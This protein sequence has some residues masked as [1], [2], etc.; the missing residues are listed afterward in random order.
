MKIFSGSKDTSTYYN[1]GA[2]KSFLNRKKGNN[3][4]YTADN[5]FKG[6]STTKSNGSQDSVKQTSKKS[7]A[8]VVKKS[9]KKID[10]ERV[11]NSIINNELKKKS[12]G[13][14][15]SNYIAFMGV[16]NLADKSDVDGT[17]TSS[18]CKS[19]KCKCSCN[20]PITVVS[21]KSSIL[22]CSEKFKQKLRQR[23]AKEKF[24]MTKVRPRRDKKSDIEVSTK[25]TKS[26]IIKKKPAKSFSTTSKSSLKSAQTQASVEIPSDQPSTSQKG[27]PKTGKSHVEFHKSASKLKQHKSMFDLEN[28]AV[29]ERASVTSS[30]HSNRNSKDQLGHA[31]GSTI[32]GHNDL[33][34][35]LVSPSYFTEQCSGEFMRGKLS[36]HVDGQSTE[37]VQK[38]E[39]KPF[40][41]HNGEP[42]RE[43]VVSVV[44]YDEPNQDC[45]LKA[46]TELISEMEVVNDIPPPNKTDA[47]ENKSSSEKV[48]PQTIPVI[49]D[50]SDSGANQPKLVTWKDLHGE[51]LQSTNLEETALVDQYTKSR[52]ESEK[53]RK[54][55]DDDISFAHALWK[56]KV[57]YQIQ[58]AFECDSLENLP[59]F[60]EEKSKK[61][62]RHFNDFENS[63]TCN[64]FIIS[65]YKK[66]PPK[67]NHP[68]LPDSDPPMTEDSLEG[69][70]CKKVNFS[71]RKVLRTYKQRL[72]PKLDED[73]SN[74]SKESIQAEEPVKVKSKKK[75]HYLTYPVQTLYSNHLPIAPKKPLPSR[76]P[77]LRKIP[78]KASRPLKKTRQVE[79]SKSFVTLS[80]DTSATSNADDRRLN[81][82]KGIKAQSVTENKRPLPP[83]QSKV[84]SR[85]VTEAA[86]RGVPKRRAE[87]RKLKSKLPVLKERDRSDTDSASQAT[88]IEMTPQHVQEV[89]TPPKEGGQKKALDRCKIEVVIHGEE[90]VGTIKEPVDDKQTSSTG[91]VEECLKLE[92]GN[93]TSCPCNKET[94]TKVTSLTLIA[95]TQ[96]EESQETPIDVECAPAHEAVKSEGVPLP[97]ITV[98]NKRYLGSEVCFAKGTADVRHFLD[99]IEVF[100]YNLRYEKDRSRSV[101]FTEASTESEHGDLSYLDSDDEIE[102]HRHQRGW[103]KQK[104]SFLKRKLASYGQSTVTIVRDCACQNEELEQ[105]NT[106]TKSPRSHRSRIPIP[107]VR[108]TQCVE[109]VPSE[110]EIQPTDNGSG[111]DESIPVIDEPSQM[112]W[113]V[114]D[115][116]G[117]DI[118]RSFTSSEPRL[119]N[120]HSMPSLSSLLGLTR[121]DVST[122]SSLSNAKRDQACESKPSKAHKSVASQ[123]FKERKP[124]ATYKIKSKASIDSMSRAA[125]KHHRERLS[126]LMA[127]FSRKRS[128][129]E[130]LNN[131]KCDRKK[132]WKEF[133]ASF[134]SN[135]STSREKPKIV[136]HCECGKRKRKSREKVA[137]PEQ[138]RT[139]ELER[140]ETQEF[141]REERPDFENLYYRQIPQGNISTYYTIFAHDCETPKSI[142]ILYPANELNTTET[143][144]S[145]TVTIA[146]AKHSKMCVNARTHSMEMLTK[147]HHEVPRSR[148]EYIESVGPFVD[149]AFCDY[150]VNGGSSCDFLNYNDK[151]QPYYHCTCGQILKIKVIKNSETS[152]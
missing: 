151:L 128:S 45:T 124:K 57:T 127:S 8:V 33:C 20:K 44:D 99:N 25:Q 85:S 14:P 31:F 39:V 112:M 111:S 105:K 135:K 115:N 7:E 23:C 61:A 140:E 3:D 54:S 106:R 67:H 130:A 113:T 58:K 34:Q 63:P 143:C 13:I 100:N 118:K 94:G 139:S 16:T 53:K 96:T 131:E 80:G 51:R 37:I 150:V 56:S 26:I 55:V 48:D 79:D 132:Y 73:V 122:T 90:Q 41:T 22:K 116:E 108:R 141:E 43:H 89:E 40:E 65:Q 9:G 30:K 92:T 50:S 27:T 76:L 36:A 144:E 91:I 6:G 146:V 59:L 121:R 78:K 68:P 136:D 126:S 87:L 12:I 5:T 102:C 70:K 82:G 52:T 42:F 49:T 19:A 149:N 103:F 28:L 95:V 134:R 81:V 2:V 11:M 38:D 46:I 47:L 35:M 93:Q 18:H 71:P 101:T 104:S 152:L 29:L 147:A 60:V 142:E 17:P 64:H 66:S 24:V 148:S 137:R 74:S 15:W 86:P 62:L 110:T 75:V 4:Y 129:K 123:F 21:R 138:K 32:F 109:I 97:S 69:E 10:K 1:A 119:N 98:Y 83:K 125:K 88:A 133:V 84:Y 72:T 120:N 145:E 117:V 114:T 107:V 77:I